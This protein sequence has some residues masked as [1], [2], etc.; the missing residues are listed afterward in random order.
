ML[1]ASFT[2]T[3]AIPSKSKGEKKEN[4]YFDICWCAEDKENQ[5]FDMQ[6]EAHRDGRCA[7][8]N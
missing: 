6:T 1:L 4:H 2:Q 7:E 5:G 8:V 3:T